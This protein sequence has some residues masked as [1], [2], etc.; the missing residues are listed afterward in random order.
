MI[1]NDVDGIYTYN[2]E[3]ERKFDCLACSNVPRPVSIEDP[4]TMTLENLISFLCENT[5]FQMKNPGESSFLRLG[6]N[7][8]GVD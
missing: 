7:G 6:L 5:E 2:F 3:S 8:Q 4:S 1:F